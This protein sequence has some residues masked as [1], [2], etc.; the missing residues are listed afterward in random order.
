MRWEMD[1]EVGG[2]GDGFSIAQAG[3]E[4]PSGDDLNGLFLEVGSS[5]GEH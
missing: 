1:D 4:N 2:H 3:R 5:R